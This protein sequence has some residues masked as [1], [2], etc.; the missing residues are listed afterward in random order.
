M[1]QTALDHAERVARE[2]MERIERPTGLTQEDFSLR[3]RREAAFDETFTPATCLELILM[4]RDA[5]ARERQ[6]REV[7]EAARKFFEA[8]QRDEDAAPVANGSEGIELEQ[9]LNTTPDA[10]GGR[11]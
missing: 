7:V 10:G 11:G 9:L 1:D 5:Q 8:V 2:V 4:Y 6:A 3:F